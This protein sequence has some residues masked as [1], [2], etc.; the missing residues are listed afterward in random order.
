MSMFTFFANSCA[1][2]L[3]IQ[4]IAGD[5]GEGSYKGAL[6]SATNPWDLRLN[7]REDDLTATVRFTRGS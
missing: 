1:Q 4:T 6:G 3:T 2:Q 5:L 7:P